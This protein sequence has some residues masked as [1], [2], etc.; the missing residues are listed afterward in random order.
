MLG[1][2]PW[3]ASLQL[4]SVQPSL[5]WAT[6]GPPGGPAQLS[7]RFCTGSGAAFTTDLDVRHRVLQ[8]PQPLCSQASCHVLQELVGGDSWGTWRG[9][10]AGLPSHCPGTSPFSG[11]ACGEPQGQVGACYVRSEGQDSRLQSARRHSVG[12]VGH[13]VCG[14]EPPA[15]QHRP[16]EG[17]CPAVAWCLSP[18]TQ[19]APPGVPVPNT[20]ETGSPEGQEAQRRERNPT[21]QVR[22]VC[23][24]SSPALGTCLGPPLLWTPGMLGGGCSPLPPRAVCHLSAFGSREHTGALRVLTVWSLHDTALTE[25]L[26]P[27]SKCH[28]ARQGSVPLAR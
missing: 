26:C 12:S 2:H 23:P 5:R 16:S 19:R 9:P 24:A 27:A 10:L 25:N 1:S 28:R 18:S 14:T 21:C 17:G 8:R 11:M 7:R 6:A 22:T 15:V 4:P 3:P 20:R 13:T